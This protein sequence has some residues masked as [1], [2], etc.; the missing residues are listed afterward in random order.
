MCWLRN[1]ALG[2]LLLIFAG[3]EQWFKKKK[4]LRP[5]FLFVP[6]LILLCTLAHVCTPQ[7]AGPNAGHSTPKSHP[8]NLLPD[9]RCTH[10]PCSPSRNADLRKKAPSGMVRS[11]N[12]WVPSTW[13]MVWKG[14]WCSL[15]SDAWKKEVGLS[16]GPEL[17]EWESLEQSAA[18]RGSDCLGLRTSF[19]VL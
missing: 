2:R 18:G 15:E 4:C 1:N 12:F 3:L 6:S 7:P 5:S 17:I 16:P 9:D 14:D 10:L 11:G 8:L 19:W 13:S